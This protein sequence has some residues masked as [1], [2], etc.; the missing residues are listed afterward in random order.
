MARLGLP[1]D[2]TRLP[3][4]QL[5]DW[6][7]EG[8]LSAVAAAEAFLAVIDAKEPQVGAW[9]HLDRALVLNQAQALDAHRKAG[10]PIG[11]LHGIPVG[12]K[13]LI[14][15]R[16]LPTENG[17][18][19]DA[20]RRPTEDANVTARLRAAGALIMGKTVTT[21]TAYFTPGKTRNPHD[22]TRTP[23]GS[24]S[25]S[26]AA[27]AAGMVPLAVGTQTMA[28]VIRPAAFCGI[29]GFKPSHG[30]IGR[31]G[32]LPLSR[33]LDTV[34]AFAADIAGVAMLVDAIEGHDPGDPD[35]APRAPSRLAEHAAA[36]PP[37]P[38]L[39]AFVETSVWDQA[40]DS[41]RAAFAELTEALSDR[42]DS[43][44]P[45]RV[46][47]EA[48]PA[49][50]RIMAAEM[51]RNLGHYMDR[52]ADALS[53]RLKQQITEGRAVTA[54]EFMAAQ[55][56]RRVLYAGLEQVFDRYDAII[57]PAA[58]GEAPVGLDA[59]GNPIFGALWT[60]LGV[61]A[62][63][64][65]LFNGPNGMPMGVQVIGRRGEDGRLLRNAG[66]LARLVAAAADGATGPVAGQQ[67]IA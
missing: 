18:A 8:A 41:T 34:G 32:I 61:P 11:P 2:P 55:D 43:I 63:T 49:H 14:D 44:D 25:G 16:D 23:G 1:A 19:A 17:T 45:G 58:A 15:T 51:A 7:A 24:S 26:A 12:L 66:A 57:T 35:T 5:R 6:L 65:P 46:F 28:S 40:E 13:D 30:L 54:V 50:K 4:G 39:F 37:V 22:P 52:A 62:I 53:D 20:G 36:E 10:R 31:S 48:F 27:V 9:A 29:T 42:C 56:W 60:F 64:L 3:V 47:A 33:A 67:E 21:E 38:P 59:T